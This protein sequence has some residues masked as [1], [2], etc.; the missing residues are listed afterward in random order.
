MLHRKRR[1]KVG[2]EQSHKERQAMNAQCRKAQVVIVEQT[3]AAEQL[4][5]LQKEDDRSEALAIEGGSNPNASSTTAITLVARQTD[6]IAQF[7]ESLSPIQ[8]ASQRQALVLQHSTQLLHDLL[9]QWTHLDQPEE[10]SASTSAMPSNNLPMDS[11]NGTS[12]V[13]GR[14]EEAPSVKLTQSNSIPAGG[15]EKMTNDAETA[16]TQQRPAYLHVQA[17][18][19]EQPAAATQRLSSR[20]ASHSGEKTTLSGPVSGLS[21]SA[22]A[23]I[24]P[25]NSGYYS[26][27]GPL[28]QHETQQVLPPRQRS[29]SLEVGV[30]SDSS[31]SSDDEAFSIGETQPRTRPRAKP[32]VPRVGATT[33]DGLEASFPSS[34]YTTGHR[35]DHHTEARY[36]YREDGVPNKGQHESPYKDPRQSKPSRRRKSGKT[37]QSSVPLIA[38]AA[39]LAGITAVL[40][41]KRRTQNEARKRNNVK[42]ATEAGKSR[43]RS[44]RK[45][46]AKNQG[47][48]G[49]DS[50]DSYYDSEESLQGR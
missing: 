38:H 6:A 16:E 34:N 44:K 43:S 3:I 9:Q 19:A 22:S 33:N 23:C 50:Y 27:F 35:E 7:Q 32:R 4:P 29:L 48:Y 10:I 41:M 12:E 31:S 36:T 21:R 40:E 14:Q 20:Y 26:G 45:P 49:S 15:A 47:S 42:K 39:N 37:E 17:G 46:Y 8:D 25:L 5:T 11:D 2:D 1:G 30:R 18:R 24:S 13:K 28:G